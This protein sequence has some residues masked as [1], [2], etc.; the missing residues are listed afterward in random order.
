M[1]TVQDTNTTAAPNEALSEAYAR[2]KKSVEAELKGAPFDKKLVTRT[3]EGVALQPLYTRADAANLPDVA[4]RPGQ[5]PYLRGTRPLGY[6]Q[7]PWEVAQEIAAASPKAFNTALVADLMHGQDS[8]VLAAN[9]AGGISDLKDLT[10]A[11]SGVDLNAIPVHLETGVDALPLASLYVTFAQK[12]K[13]DLTKLTGSV[14]ADPLGEWVKSGR[15]PRTVAAHF[16]DVAGW[17]TWAAANAPQLRTIGVNGRVW[18]EA[19]GNAVHELAFSLASA[20]EYLRALSERGLDASSAASR[21]R[22]QFAVGPQFFTE[23]AKFRA[24]R[25]L[26]TRVVVAFGASEETAAKALVHAATCRWNKT[27]LDVN[28]NMLRV[29]TEALSAV[30]GGC[31]SLHITPYDEVLGTTDDFSRRIARNVHTLL[32]EEFSFTQTADPAGGSWYVEK[33][34]DEL[35]RKAWAVFQQIEAAGGYVAALRAG[36][37]QKLVTEAAAEK[38]DAVGKRRLGLI[39]TNLFP[40][41]KEKPVAAAKAAAKR[42]SKAKKSVA[43]PAVAQNASWSDRFAA[44]TKAAA[45]G[46]S[47]DGLAQL[48]PAAGSADAAITAVHPFRASAGFEQLRSAS[49]AFAAKS[50]KRPQVF[51]AKMGPAL[52]HKARADFSSGFFAAGGFEIQGRQAFDTPEAAAKAAADSGAPVVV[53]CSTDDT[54]PALVPSFAG[55]VKAATGGKIAVV[56]AGLPAD[57]AAVESFRKAG[58]DEFIHVRANVRDVLA[59][60]LKQIGALE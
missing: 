4:S 46:A 44:A 53:L 13:F 8:V 48:E 33:L 26:W 7:R 2:W 54:Y 19:G 58:I 45:D 20:A 34:T 21:I 5:A 59:K 37:P 55:A 22:F 25:A 40:N 16:D 43:A 42:A 12:K 9:D 32:A 30:L 57:A 38:M 11:L 56:L 6:K 10:A 31:D 29:T 51:L 1:S 28:V 35:A 17:T 18:A 24:F 27:R 47:I 60:F 36:L 50:G 3:F 14:A 41:L 39:G 49:D 52:Q 23:V 15:L